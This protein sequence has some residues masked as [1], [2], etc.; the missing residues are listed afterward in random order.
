MKIAIIGSRKL[1]IKTEEIKR[2]LEKIT[3]LKN[4][5]VIVSGGATGADQAAK[6]AAKE[7]NIKSR[8]L[9]LDFNYITY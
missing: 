5:K 2:E 8:N 6:T 1:N 3:K 4:I 9:I 7:L